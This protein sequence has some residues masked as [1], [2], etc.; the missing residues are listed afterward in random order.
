MDVVDMTHGDETPE[1]VE[2]SFDPIGQL[3]LDNLSSSGVG[4]PPQIK[5]TLRSKDKL[6]SIEG[7][8]ILEQYE[9]RITWNLGNLLTLRVSE[10]MSVKLNKLTI[11]IGIQTLIFR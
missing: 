2:M 7:L 3:M 10:L 8:K 4:D 1:T 9:D 11:S 6:K 5:G